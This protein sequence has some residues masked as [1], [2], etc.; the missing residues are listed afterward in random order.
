MEK[1]TSTYI[2]LDVP[3]PPFPNLSFF[4]EAQWR[5]L[6]ALCDAVVPSIRTAATVKSSSH[7]VISIGEWDAALSKLTSLIPGPDA[8][9]IAT[10][11]LEEDASSNPVFRSYVGRILGDY[12][13]EDGKA[14]FGLIM[15]ALKY[16][17]VVV[18][19]KGEKGWLTGLAAL[20][21][22]H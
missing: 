9:H 1:T 18:C 16:E 17:S 20:G 3:L 11:Y 5:T 21:P 22:G 19:F 15:N 14:G 10:R 13:H 6:F 7:K 12:V 8:A 2:P 4:S